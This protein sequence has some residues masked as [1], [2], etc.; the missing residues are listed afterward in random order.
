M[1]YVI[2]YD[3]VHDLGYFLRKL[4]DAGLTI[5][6]G[7]HIV[8]EDHS[9][10]STL[11]LYKEGRLIAY[12]VAHYIT[13]YYRA[14]LSENQGND[15]AFLEQL[16]RIKHSGERW[17]IPVNPIY[18]VLIDSEFA[19]ILEKYEDSYPINDGEKLVETYRSKNPNYKHIPR[20]V[21]ARLVEI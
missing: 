19:N 1:V 20:V 12:V 3:K 5:E 17:S 14:V 13:Q 6:H 16:L 21:V 2:A 8:L 10:I 9:E 18:M 11:K 7:P 4:N 15:I